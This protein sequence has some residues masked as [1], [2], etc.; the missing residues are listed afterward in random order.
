MSEGVEAGGESGAPST[1]K[2]LEGPS[3]VGRLER[4][5][6]EEEGEEEEDGER[7]SNILT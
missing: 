6:G 7:G 2:L 4:E 5:A 3:M 1:R